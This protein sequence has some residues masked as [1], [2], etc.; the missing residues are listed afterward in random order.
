[1]R[2]PCAAAL[3]SQP[4]ALAYAVLPPDILRDQLHLVR[5]SAAR[6]HDQLR[7]HHRGTTIAHA[8]TTVHLLIFQNRAAT[9]LGLGWYRPLQQRLQPGKLLECPVDGCFAL[10]ADSMDRCYVEA[11]YAHLYSSRSSV[12]RSLRLNSIGASSTFIGVMVRPTSTI[13]FFNRSTSR[14]RRRLS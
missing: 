2:R 9:S 11:A 14:W 5:S 4:Y 12:W 8:L 6:R 1:M 10:A 3:S 13:S 7:H